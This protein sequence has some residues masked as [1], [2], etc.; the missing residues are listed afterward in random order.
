MYKKSRLCVY[1]ARWWH[2]ESNDNKILYLNSEEARKGERER[3][4]RRHATRS[5]KY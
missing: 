3:G 2:R 4:T 1:K 5:A